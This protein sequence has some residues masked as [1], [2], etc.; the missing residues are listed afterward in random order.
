MALRHLLDEG[1]RST[2]PAPLAPD[3]VSDEVRARWRSRLASG[4]EMSEIEGLRLLADYG[5]PVVPARSASSADEAVAAAEEIGWP[6]V[7][8]T[9]AP[10]IQHKSDVGGVVVGLWD[11]SSLRAAYDDLAG[12][13]GP[14]VTVT[15]LAPAGV[16]LALGVVRDP[17]FGPL[18]LVAAGG[19]LVELLGDR[20][21]AF[22]HLDEAEAHR[23]LDGLLVRPMLEGVRGAPASDVDAVAHAVSRLSVLAADLGDRLQALD[24]NPLIAGPGGC[25]AVDAL[26]IPR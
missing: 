23:L 5:V 20:R 7:L 11:G 8:K 6:A 14:R 21:L 17:T 12:R 16:E 1:E 9:A 26:V 10:G 25:V 24:V 2:R 22:P 13:L 19:V 15:A 4:A 18:V 3:P